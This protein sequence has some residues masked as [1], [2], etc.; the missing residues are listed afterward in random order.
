M[1]KLVVVK[2]GTSLLT[3]E[4]G[5]INASFIADLCEE[6][7]EIKEAGW[8]IIV[9][10]SG[11]M[12]SGKG[13][14]NKWEISDMQERHLLSTIGQPILM[15]YYCD[16][17]RLQGLIAGQC[18]L[19]WDNF[20][21]D[22]ERKILKENFKTMLLNGIVPIV[23]ENDFIANDE[24][25]GDNDTIAAKVASLLGAEKLII[26][27][28]VDGLYDKNPQVDPSAIRIERVEEITDEIWG[29]IGEKKSKNSLGGMKSKVLAAQLAMDSGV[30]VVL[31]RG[32]LGGQS[33]KG[34]ILENK[35][36]GTLF[37]GKK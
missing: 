13:R 14:M 24:L 21:N 4:N 10:S 27:S 9:V 23:N 36:L 19:T 35:K 12:A 7:G 2:V 8:D 15:N 29:Y 18:L 32:K 1:R 22:I 5:N 25:K 16:F 33:T 20:D 6:I 37:V 26:F 3:R 30:D 31:L 28:D 34:I 11:A 17:L